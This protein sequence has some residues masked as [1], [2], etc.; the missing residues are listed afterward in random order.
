MY[1]LPY[2]ILV[3]AIVWEL[4]HGKLA[5]CQSRAPGR[6]ILTKCLPR[7]TVQPIEAALRN[8]NEIICKHRKLRVHVSGKVS[9]KSGL[10]VR[11]CTM[12]NATGWII[13]ETH[14]RNCYESVQYND[15]FQFVYLFRQQTDFARFTVLARVCDSYDGQINKVR[16]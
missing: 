3:N 14:N 5:A 16:M 4:G 13:A 7:D 11:T 12:L 8:S 1:L 15:I 10:T 2:C 9:G 6:V